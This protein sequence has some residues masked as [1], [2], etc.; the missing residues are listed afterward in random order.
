MRT[1]SPIG[2]LAA[3]AFVAAISCSTQRGNSPETSQKDV[4]SP[5]VNFSFE[6][7]DVHLVINAISKI[8]GVN[9]ITTPEL[10]GNVSLQL[11]DVSW[12]FALEQAVKPLG[13]EVIE[14]EKGILR[15]VASKK[16]QTT[17]D[18]IPE[19][20]DRTKGRIQDTHQSTSTREG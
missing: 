15:I 10:V 7:A 13:F 8:S 2:F 14:L 1:Q 6:D 20:E 4:V 17:L 16:K 3:A 5:R 19:G 12:K 11:R 9:I 18:V